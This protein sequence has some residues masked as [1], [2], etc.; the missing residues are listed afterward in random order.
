MGLE[1][2]TRPAA[3]WGPIFHSPKFTTR[4][5]LLWSSPTPCRSWGK[6]T[7]AWRGEGAWV[8]S[9]LSLPPLWLLVLDSFLS[10]HLRWLQGLSTTEQCQPLSQCFSHTRK[11]YTSPKHTHNHAR[12]HTCL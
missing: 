1:G 2:A 10:W 8:F 4:H 11:H 3:V 9:S 5:F 6:W 12:C 7:V